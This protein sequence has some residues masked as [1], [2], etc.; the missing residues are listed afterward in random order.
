VNGLVAVKFRPRKTGTRPRALFF[1]QVQ[2]QV[3]MAGPL[4]SRLKYT[5]ICLR[6]SLPA[7]SAGAWFDALEVHFGRPGPLGV[8]P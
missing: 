1:G 8:R 7:E 4:S 6:N 5:V 2:Q 3:S